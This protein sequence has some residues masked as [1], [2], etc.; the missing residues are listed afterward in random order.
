MA[1][2]EDKTVVKKGG[3]KAEAPAEPPM[4]MPPNPIKQ[5]LPMLLVYASRGT[6]FTTAD[7]L[8]YLRVAFGVVQATTLLISLLLYMRIARVKDTSELTVVEKAGAEPRKELVHEHDLRH[9]TMFVRA[10]TFTTAIIVGMHLK[11]GYSQPLLFTSATGLTN[12]IDGAQSKLMRL[13][14]F[15]AQVARPFDVVAAPSWLEQKRAELEQKKEDLDKKKAK[16]A[17]RSKKVD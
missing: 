9:L 15:G 3:G 8:F 12:L 1:T 16:A 7:N 5:M 4:A 14:L 13:Y 2:S 11:L 10:T 6:D 17:K